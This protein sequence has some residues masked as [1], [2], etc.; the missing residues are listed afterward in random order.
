MTTADSVPNLE[1]LANC[2]VRD[3]VPVLGLFGRFHRLD[4]NI[5]EAE[6]FVE[7]TGTANVD[8][9]SFQP[10][11]LVNRLSQF[12]PTYG[13][14]VDGRFMVGDYRFLDHEDTIRPRCDARRVR[15]FVSEFLDAVENR[16][17]R[18][19]SSI[20]IEVLGDREEH[21]GPF[22]V[23]DP[24]DCP[25]HKELAC[26][27]YP[28]FEEFL[29]Y[30]VVEAFLQM[31]ELAEEPHQKFVHGHL[32]ADVVSRHGGNRTCVH[33]WRAALMPEPTD[34]CALCGDPYHP[35]QCRVV[36]DT[37]PTPTGPLEIQCGCPGYEP[38]VDEDDQ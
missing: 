12:G 16:A 9:L 7:A 24:F 11:A 1:P 30:Q 33:A 14:A 8:R 6:L 35:G 15:T 25:V 22:F 37:C 21:L 17:E 5:A 29:G 34:D 27:W 20:A 23:A 38:P 28:N 18:A 19:K 36:V 3:T 4:R 32:S 2:A 26:S 10:Q 31:G 13:G